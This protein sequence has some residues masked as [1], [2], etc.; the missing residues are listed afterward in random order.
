[1]EDLRDGDAVLDRNALIKTYARV[2]DSILSTAD[3]DY[4]PKEKLAFWRASKGNIPITQ[5]RLAETTV[6][7]D[8]FQIDALMESEEWLAKE[9][10]FRSV[11]C[12]DYLG[13][14][15]HGRP[16]MVERVG[17]WD[18]NEVLAYTAVNSHDKDGVKDDDNVSSFLKLHCI[19]CETKLRMERPPLTL[20]SRGQV[21]IMDCAGLSVK[22][23]S[24][25]LA[26]AFGKLAAHDERHYPDTI[27]HIFVVNAPYVFK[28]LSILIQP[29]M[30]KDT[31]SK[32]HVS[33]GI[34]C[35]LVDF[36]GVDCLPEE[37]GGRRQSIFPYD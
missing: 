31:L 21:V 22:H 15:R 1:M 6:W 33:S 8:A 25:S 37:L 9:R 4:S 30:D 17:A 20:D 16:V 26:K 27:A 23:L 10:A 35:E 13:T 5:Q 32:V 18:V 3:F 2:L 29:F 24:P 36:L 19:A 14:D 7:R 11:L 12:Y 34:P 28:A